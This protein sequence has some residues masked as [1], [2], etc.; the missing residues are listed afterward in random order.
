MISCHDPAREAIVS[1]TSAVPVSFSPIYADHTSSESS[2][3][4]N[5]IRN[6]VFNSTNTWLFA[7]PTLGRLK[8]PLLLHLGFVE[9]GYTLECPDLEIFESGETVESALNEFYDFLIGD[10]QNWLATPDEE[11][12]SSA[13]ELKRKY[14]TYLG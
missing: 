3:P 9:N 11:L 1:R 13:K 8:K 14:L 4:C 7:I 12:E 2:G 10:Y 6:L 5:E